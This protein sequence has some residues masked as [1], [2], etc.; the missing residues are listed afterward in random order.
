MDGADRA[1]R[2]SYIKQDS[3]KDTTYMH[4]GVFVIAA[5]SHRDRATPVYTV[6]SQVAL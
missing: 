3:T 6:V 1:I 4:L 5:C 2:V